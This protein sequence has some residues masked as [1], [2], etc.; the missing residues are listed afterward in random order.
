MRGAAT[1]G[2][3]ALM[4]SSASAQQQ[5]LP[6]DDF[7]ELERI[8]RLLEV[9]GAKSMTLEHVAPGLPELTFVTDQTSVE[10]EKAF[11]RQWL[12]AYEAICVGVIDAAT[13]ACGDALKDRERE[14]EPRRRIKPVLKK[15]KKLARKDPV[16]AEAKALLEAVLPTFERVLVAQRDDD[17]GRIFERRTQETDAFLKRYD[18]GPKIATATRRGTAVI[19]VQLPPE[20][21]ALVKGELDSWR[22]TPLLDAEGEQVQ[23]RGKS[24]EWGEQLMQGQVREALQRLDDQE[25]FTVRYAEVKNELPTGEFARVTGARLTLGAYL[26]FQY[27]DRFMVFRMGER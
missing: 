22:Y 18:F 14:K 11:R 3:I 19:E 20:T 8:S 23:L 27:G 5:D 7:A 4:V 10:R 26:F 6:L 25:F 15:L 16:A 12:E 13:E 2:W 9:Q 17:E 24:V 21:W 1:I